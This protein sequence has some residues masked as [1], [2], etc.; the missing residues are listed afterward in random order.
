VA[1]SDKPSSQPADASGAPVVDPA[2]PADTASEGRDVALIHGRTD[3]GAGLK[4]LRARNDRIE[5]GVLRPL[6]EGQA[7]VGEVVRLEP[8]KEFPLLCDVKVEVDARPPATRGVRHGPAQVAT[9]SYRKNWD[10][11][12]NRRS[13]DELL[14]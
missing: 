1:Q 11:I 9:D 8:R 13:D 14:N 6:V 7:I 5:T 3:D 10:A 4:V 2:G 12:Y